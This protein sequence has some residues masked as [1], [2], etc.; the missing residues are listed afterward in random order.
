MPWS[1]SPR[2]IAVFCAA[3]DSGAGAATGGAAVMVSTGRE[4]RASACTVRVEIVTTIAAS[5]IDEAPAITQIRSGVF[6]LKLRDFRFMTIPIFYQF[7]TGLPQL[8]ARLTRVF[9]LKKSLISGLFSI[10][11][12]CGWS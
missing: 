7:A 5:A 11:L 1:L 8:L 12:S 9:V 10:T 6:R 2:S 3:S 4:S